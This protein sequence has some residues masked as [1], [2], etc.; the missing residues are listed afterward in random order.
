M[1]CCQLGS[2]FIHHGRCKRSVNNDPSPLNPQLST[3]NPQPSTFYPQTSIRSQCRAEV[4]VISLWSHPPQ[5]QLLSF[6]LPLL[7]F[8]PFLSTL[9]I[10]NPKPYHSFGFEYNFIA[11]LA[12]SA[13]S[14]FIVAFYIPDRPRHGQ[15]GEASTGPRTSELLAVLSRP[16]V[17]LFFLEIFVFGMAMG[18]SDLNP[19]QP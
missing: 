11:Y 14:I 17:F 2:R 16:P 1:D 4:I 9:P 18:A 8:L 7:L 13:L 19:S 6:P 10:L 5:S 12:F 15:G 3:L